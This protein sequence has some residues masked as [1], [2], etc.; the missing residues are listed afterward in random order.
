MNAFSSDPTS[1]PEERL[2]RVLAEY[3]RQVEAGIEV[4]RQ[5]L[6]AAHPELADDLQS[7]FRNHDEIERLAKPLRRGSSSSGDDPTVGLVETPNVEDHRV[8][9]FGDY[10]LLAEIARGGMGVVYKARQLSL[11]RLVALKMILAG[12][13]ASKADVDR[14]Q[15]E[16]EHAANL[17]HPNIVPIYEIGV[18]EGRHYFSMKLIEGSNL[19]SELPRLQ[20]DLTVGI[21][22]MSEAAR[23]VHHAHQRGVLHR[24]L[25]PNNILIDRDGEPHITDFG[26][27]R[28]VEGD[29][30][31]TQSGA[32]V[33]TPSYMA[34]EQA[35]GE[36]QLSTAADVYSLGAI[37]YELLAGRPPF[38]A[39]TPMETIVQVVSQDPERPSTTLHRI[40]RDLETT[41][42]KC[43]EKDPRR[44]YDSAAAL[45]DDLDRWLRGEPILARPVGRWERTARWCRRNPLIA[46][47]TATVA[48]SLVLGM[49]VSSYFAAAARRSAEEARHEQLRAEANADLAQQQKLRADLK[50]DAA[51]QAS[52]MLLAEKVLGDRSLYAARMNLVQR[53]WEAHRM[54]EVLEGLGRPSRIDPLEWST[55]Q[56]RA[57]LL[58]PPR[59]DLRGFE[60]FYWERRFHSER[61][62]LKEPLAPSAHPSGARAVAFS[63]NGLKIATGGDD[64][65]LK[66]WNASD[67]RLLHSLRGH[68]DSLN[69]V[70]FSADGTRVVSAGGAADGVKVWDVAT[71]KL[72]NTFVVSSGE[73]KLVPWQVAFHP[74]GSRLA[75]A[76]YDESIRVWDLATG[77]EL[78]SLNAH[79]G[80]FSSLAYSPEGKH[81][82]AGSFE[83]GTITL[84][85]A[86]DG[87]L[88]QTLEGHQGKVADVEFSSDGTRLA[89]A[90]WDKTV[91]LWNVADGKQLNVF[92][93]HTDFVHGVAFSPN[94]KRLASGGQDAT[95]CIWDLPNGGN[96]L[97]IQGGI[98]AVSGISF[99]PDGAH[100]AT[101]HLDGDVKIWDAAL[102]QESRVLAEEPNAP[103]SCV[104]CSPNSQW[105]ATAGSGSIVNVWNRKQERVHR[106]T[107]HVGRIT[108]V[109]F[110]PDDRYVV[111]AGNDR[112]I[113]V[114]DL[115]SGKQKAVWNGH[116]LPINS[117]ALSADGRWLASAAGDPFR[118]GEPSESQAELKLWDFATGN[119][120][121]NL[122]GHK[123]AVVSVAFRS[124]GKQLASI[125]ADESG[126]MLWDTI[127]G[128][129]MKT[130]AVPNKALHSVTYS[131]DGRQ[132]AVSSQD[133]TAQI[134]DIE[135]GRLLWTLDGH[136]ASV[137]SVAYSPDGRRL[138][139]AGRDKT[140]RLWDVDSGQEV[141]TLSGHTG[142]VSAVV[143][144]ADGNRLISAG[145]DGA[146]RIWEAT[147]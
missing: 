114:W 106:F 85:D 45:A 121:R 6:I 81:L 128:S 141:L 126:V 117:I 140:V 3:L 123:Q 35:R 14:F 20:K 59:R 7:F 43:L 136:A 145:H 122:I 65:L 40:D 134:F 8:R 69:H 21:R 92:K 86:T 64:R 2:E 119:E 107:G 56:L 4:D 19:R 96:E 124:D 95:A 116:K 29:S 15:Q 102:G 25:K 68:K 80:G 88:L 9:Y 18:H 53:N 60:W 105:I 143:F 138:A 115:A 112:T 32:I 48:V 30:D 133:G 26:L 142:P 28:R 62:N 34:P 27:A 111:S 99:S 118:R 16:A 61:L 130:P 109:V 54:R 10:E 110:S 42:L 90:G 113:R 147:R 57:G 108:S 135:S 70:A 1:S 91:R 76:S 98:Y 87:K 41:A 5:A 75:V 103:L 23:A 101:A 58:P 89:S 131:P 17:D 125:G 13:F 83:R 36:K 46:G 78:P 79:A 55:E 127:N 12:Q 52:N 47:L 74:D 37:L 67:G 38:K 49:L 93:R 50:A 94:G 77:K 11:N 120:V 73:I 31:L 82:A 51:L 100:L 22:L 71:G 97:L 44:R 24:D 72:L 84:W 129:G 146:A 39:A 132:L 104:A 66:L 33:G 63:P 144:S 139:T 137:L